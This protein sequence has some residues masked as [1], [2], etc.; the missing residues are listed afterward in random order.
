MRETWEIVD[1]VCGQCRGRLVRR[2][3][4]D[5]DAREWLY[6]CTN[7]GTVGVGESRGHPKICACAIRVGA[8]KKSPGREVGVHCMVN[9]APSPEMPCEIVVGEG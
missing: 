4:D 1:H 3:P 6:R 2:R 8:N 7:C 5:D 9:P